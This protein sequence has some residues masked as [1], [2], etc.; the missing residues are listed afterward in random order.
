MTEAKSESSLSEE[1]LK[2]LLDNGQEIVVSKSKY[3]PTKFLIEKGKVYF[4]N[5]EISFGWNEH[6]SMKS[7]EELIAWL[8]GMQ[9]DGYTLKSEDRTDW[10]EDINESQK[11]T[12]D[13]DADFK[14]LNK[15]QSELRGVNIVYD[16][17]EG[18]ALELSDEEYKEW[19]KKTERVHELVNKLYSY[20]NLSENEKADRLIKDYFNYKIKSLDELHS[21]LE[22]LFDTKKDAVEY[23]ANNETRL[24]KAAKLDESKKL[25]TETKQVNNMKIKYNKIYDKYDVIT[26]DGRALEEFDTEE[27]AVKWAKEQKDFISKK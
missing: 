27:E 15:L 17:K 18:K 16:D 3:T 24:K 2:N 10:N 21:K 25:M 4:N 12:E 13:D 6:P 26:P 7:E 5:R 9:L 20:T 8:L 22:K 14:E 1:D 19:E 23:F 11:L